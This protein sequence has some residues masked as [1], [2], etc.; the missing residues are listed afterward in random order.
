[1]SFDVSAN[2]NVLTLFFV[3]GMF[4]CCSI[5]AQCPLSQNGT[6]SHHQCGCPGNRKDSA[7]TKL[8]AR[9]FGS[10]HESHTTGWSTC[11]PRSYRQRWVKSKGRNGA[12]EI[13]LK[14]LVFFSHYHHKKTTTKTKTSP[15][16][17]S[18]FVCLFVVVPFIQHFLHTVNQ[19]GLNVGNSV[20]QVPCLQSFQSSY[21]IRM[22]FHPDHTFSRTI[23]ILLL[24]F[25]NFGKE[26]FQNSLIVYVPK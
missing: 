11:T 16:I 15:E 5:I 13:K 9:A 26:P 4:A 24:S 22:I 20:T 14:T 19:I 3:V 8:C 21:R 25:G 2:D 10:K 7:R 23:N 6:Q 17:L 12:A 1:M 18:L